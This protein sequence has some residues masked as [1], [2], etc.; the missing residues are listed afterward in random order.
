MESC[1]LGFAI[2]AKVTTAATHTPPPSRTTKIAIAALLYII[3]FKY[4]ICFSISSLILS[5][6]IS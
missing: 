1:W 3:S 4:S 2:L 6:G 5:S